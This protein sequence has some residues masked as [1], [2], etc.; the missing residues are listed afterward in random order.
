[1]RKFWFDA[2]LIAAVAVGYAVA[3]DSPAPLLKPNAALSVPNGAAPKPAASPRAPG[4]YREPMGIPTVTLVQQRVPGAG[5]DWSV[6]DATN[7]S[8]LAAAPLPDDIPAV[9]ALQEQV[10]ETLMV[11]VRRQ[12]DMQVTASDQMTNVRDYRT[13]LRTGDPELLKLQQ[14]MEE[15]NREREALN[16]QIDERFN[17]DNQYQKMTEQR[18]GGLQ[19]LRDMGALMSALREKLAR[20]EQ[21]QAELER[22]D[23]MAATNQPLNATPAV[24]I[25]Q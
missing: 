13:K 10:R 14:R 8:R 20:L 1:M 18:V 11:L 3:A 6:S 19:K 16:R 17:Q 9:R 5:M 24:T 25:K 4:S 2:A 22:R 7:A 21:K 23:A 12:V 15:L